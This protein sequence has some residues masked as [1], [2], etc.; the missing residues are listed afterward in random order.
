MEAASE[1]IARWIVAR[2]PRSGDR[3]AALDVASGR[4]R[5]ACLLAEAGYETFAVDCDV[6]RLRAAGREAGSRG[7][8]LR[9]WAADLERQ[10]LPAARFD[11]VVCVRYLQRNLFPAL[12]RTLRP[13]GILL[14]E[15]FTTGQLAHGTGPRSPDH[16]LQPGELRALFADWDLLEYEETDTP[17]AVAR[18]AARRPAGRSPTAG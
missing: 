10:P 17:E 18:L 8:R 9:S 6:E 16:L 13:G 14:Y 4:G 15:T 1:F 3:V 11:L 5:Y 12:R 7:R 2:R